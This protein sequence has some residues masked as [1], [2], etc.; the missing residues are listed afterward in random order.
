MFTIFYFLL[1][2]QVHFSRS[3]FTVTSVAFCRVTFTFTQVQNKCTCY[4]NVGG[5]RNNKLRVLSYHVLYRFTEHTRAVTSV[6]DSVKICR[7]ETSSNPPS[8]GSFITP[9]ESKT[10]ITVNVCQTKMSVGILQKCGHGV[11]IGTRA[12]SMVER[13]HANGA[14]FE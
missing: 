3:S 14:L 5:R 1:S 8:A 10:H 13:H 7:M 2:L 9:Y 6:S 4:S 11:P 12:P